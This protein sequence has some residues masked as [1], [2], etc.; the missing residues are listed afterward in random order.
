MTVRT[1]REMELA[2][3]SPVPT[4]NPDNPLKLRELTLSKTYYPLGFPLEVRTNSPVILEMNDKLW[5]RFTHEHDTAPIR[6][7]VHVTEGGGPEC[8]PALSCQY[9]AP[10][11]VNIADPQHYTVIDLVHGETVISVTEASLRHRLYIEYFYLFAPLTTIPAK[12]VH[13]GCVAWNGRGILLC[14]DSGAGKSTLSYACARSGWEY[15]SDD[16]SFVIDEEQPIVT[17]NSHLVRLRP[18]V[19]ELFPE[20]QGMDQTPRAA[21]KPSIE[22]S[23]LRL[24][25]IIRRQ[26][27]CVDFIVFLKR[28]STSPAQLVPYRKEV[29]RMY[30]REGIYGSSE[31]RDRHFAAIE[32]LLTADVFELQ[33]SDLGS[34]IERLRRLVEDGH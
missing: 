23:T 33:Y 27:V 8:P 6:A 13:A 12:A 30:M 7:Y 16:G 26:R 5:G 10:Y 1:V 29:A 14:G 21:G 32:R 34:A 19:A 17:G 22:I 3:D 18:S 24:P 28:G 25:R 9:V 11:F 20:I 2:C 31:I 15:I 4:E